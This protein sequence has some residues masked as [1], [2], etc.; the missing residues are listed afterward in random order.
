LAVLVDRGHR[1]LPVQPDVAGMIVTTLH[2]EKVRVRIEPVDLEDE[3]VKIA[4]SW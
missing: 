2:E 4:P 3:I 1:E